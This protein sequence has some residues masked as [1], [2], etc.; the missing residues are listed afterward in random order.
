MKSALTASLAFQMGK[1]RREVLDLELFQQTEWR[2]RAEERRNDRRLHKESEL[3]RED[4]RKRKKKGPYITSSQAVYPSGSII[5]SFFDD[6]DEHLTESRSLLV[7]GSKTSTKPKHSKMT[8]DERP[9]SS[10]GSVKQKESK[11]ILPPNESSNVSIK[12]K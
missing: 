12:Q 10:R 6:E 11:V 2:E 5:N 9:Q 8:L 4:E 3:R 1:E 7:P